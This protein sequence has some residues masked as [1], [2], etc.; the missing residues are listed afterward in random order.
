MIHLK[1]LIVDS[2]DDS[3]DEEQVPDDNFMLELAAQVVARRMKWVG[4]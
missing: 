4:E 3:L 1:G 2:I